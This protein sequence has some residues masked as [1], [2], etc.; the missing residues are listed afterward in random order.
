MHY[1]GWH[2]RWQCVHVQLSVNCVFESNQ[3]VGNGG[4]IQYDT[5]SQPSLLTNTL[6][7]NNTANGPN[8]LGGAVYGMDSASLVVA[9][10]T[11][12][13]NQVGKRCSTL[14][15]PVLCITAT[16]GQGLACTM[17]LLPAQAFRHGAIHLTNTS[18]EMA[19]STFSQNIGTNGGGAC[20]QPSLLL[21]SMCQ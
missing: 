19:D 17:L 21:P 14:I 2:Q 7:L 13:A 20:T 6:F 15:L 1:A 3:A 9:A 4:S 5:C 11:F 18:L 12:T 16:H 10:C 8:A